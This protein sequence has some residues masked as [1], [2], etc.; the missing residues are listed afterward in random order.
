MPFYFGT[1]FPAHLRGVAAIVARAQRP[2]AAKGTRAGSLRGFVVHGVGS[3]LEEP[4]AALNSASEAASPP[5]HSAS[6]P[7]APPAAS[8]APATMIWAA[9]NEG[10]SGSG[11][12]PGVEPSFFAARA[13]AG[14]N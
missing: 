7:D 9:R 1:F 10:L 4:G 6:P 11:D 5:A 2:V 12:G 3:A 14:I 13:T 8:T